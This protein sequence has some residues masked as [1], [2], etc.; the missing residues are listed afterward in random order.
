ME[1]ENLFKPKVTGDTCKNCEHSQRW[2]CN[3]KFFYYCGIT[4]SGRTDNGLKKI[5][6]KDVAC[7]KYKQME[8]TK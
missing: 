4:A 7:G 3:S 5:K 1:Q 6:L 8:E 2:E